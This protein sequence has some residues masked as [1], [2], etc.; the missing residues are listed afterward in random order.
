[1]VLRQFMGKAMHSFK[2]AVD[3]P[4]GKCYTKDLS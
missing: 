2:S 1:M 4:K 3:G